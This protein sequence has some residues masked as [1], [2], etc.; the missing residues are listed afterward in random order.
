MRNT[1]EKLYDGRTS[2]KRESRCILEEAKTKS[3]GSSALLRSQGL[4]CSHGCS[5]G[6]LPLRALWLDLD[7][8]SQYY[9]NKSRLQTYP[10]HTSI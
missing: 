4:E 7:M 9:R 3:N 1:R 6:T 8:T 5:L 2:Q 10:V